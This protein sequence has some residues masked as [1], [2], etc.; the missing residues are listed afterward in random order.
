MLF[1]FLTVLRFLL[2]YVQKTGMAI[3]NCIS[4]L[5]YADESDVIIRN[6][7][8]GM[9]E[10]AKCFC[11]T[12]HYLAAETESIHVETKVP[13]VEYNH[14]VNGN[15]FDLVNFIFCF[16]HPKQYEQV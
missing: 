4:S 2:L 11:Q 8:I 13:S 1:C 10:A 3:C 12:C 16:L 5:S 15:F 14:E 7:S 9:H 6:D